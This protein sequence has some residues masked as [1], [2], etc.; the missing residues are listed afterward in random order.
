ME[1]VHALVQ[2]HDEG[3]C[4][5]LG[6]LQLPQRLLEMMLVHAMNSFLHLKIYSIF[7]EAIRSQLDSYVKTVRVGRG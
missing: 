6:D 4:K 1:W 3:L 2:L 5:R 7:E